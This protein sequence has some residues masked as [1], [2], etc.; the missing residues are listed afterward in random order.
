MAGSLAATLG[1]Y[2]RIAAR[3]KFSRL[4]SGNDVSRG[5][6]I[7]AKGTT[8]VLPNSVVLVVVVVVAIVV[9]SISGNPPSHVCVASWGGGEEKI[10]FPTSAS[11]YA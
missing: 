10:L 9:P 5:R 1:P 11:L 2:L 7:N 6:D 3:T 4:P 8:F